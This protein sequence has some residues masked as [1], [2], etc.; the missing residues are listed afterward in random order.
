MF[1]CAKSLHSCLTVC[2]TLDCSPP[3]SSVHGI[4]QARILECV[5][6]SPSRGSSLRLFSFFN[7]NWFKNYYRVIFKSISVKKMSLNLNTST[8]FLE[9]VKHNFSLSIK[10]PHTSS[11]LENPMDRVAWRANTHKHIHT[12]TLQS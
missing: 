4:L 10:V 8:L 11:Y 1:M 5:T 3:G 7:W 12:H 9:K 6:V 2:D